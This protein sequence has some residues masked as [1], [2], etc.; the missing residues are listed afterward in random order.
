MQ[1]V[2]LSC[3]LSFFISNKFSPANIANIA[4]VSCMLIFLEAEHSTYLTA[5][6][7]LAIRRPVHYWISVWFHKALTGVKGLY[8]GHRSF[9]KAGNYIYLLL[10]IW[11]AGALGRL[12]TSRLGTDSLSDHV[13]R[14]WFRRE[15][16]A[17]AVPN[18]EAPE[19]TRP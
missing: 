15:Q 16:W 7:C 2:T 10:L 3:S 18:V 13:G 4:N 17:Y 11:H 5:P 6:I 14:S 12:Q 8:L 9:C 19:P 1:L